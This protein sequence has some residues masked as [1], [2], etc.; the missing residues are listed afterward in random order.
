MGSPC[1]SQ[2]SGRLGGRLFIISHIYRVYAYNNAL[3]VTKFNDS[4]KLGYNYL[5]VFHMIL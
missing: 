1:S 2:C 3:N 5:L 4:P